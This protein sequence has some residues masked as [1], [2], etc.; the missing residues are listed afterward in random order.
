[1]SLEEGVR[2]MQ[3]NRKEH[4]LQIARCLL[5]EKDWNEVT[6]GG[7][8]AESG[9]SRVT[10]Y[11]YFNSL[12]DIIYE[13]QLQC[14]REITASQST[15]SHPNASG[16]E[17]LSMY[18]RGAVETFKD[19]MEQYRFIALFDHHYR[20]NFPSEEFRLNYRAATQ[21]DFLRLREVLQEGMED[22]SLRSEFDLDML[23]WTF[24]QTLFSMLQRMAVRGQLIEKQWG[25]RPED[26]IEYL[27]LFLSQFTKTNPDPTV[28]VRQ[29]PR[30]SDSE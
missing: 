10:V 7:I 4:I 20:I 26:V 19:N 13:I 17:K 9:V 27:T 11:K 5:L 14:L 25:I 28:F 3:L 24:S 12:H 21:D 23:T 22:G 1:M 16:A 8:A 2:E 6:L 29:E 30:H 15:M 18:M